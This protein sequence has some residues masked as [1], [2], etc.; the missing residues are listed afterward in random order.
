MNYKGASDIARQL[1]TSD[2]LTLNQR[3]QG[4]SPCAPT[5]ENR[6]LAKNRGCRSRRAEQLRTLCGPGGWRFVAADVGSTPM[7]YFAHGAAATGQPRARYRPVGQILGRRADFQHNILS[8][9][10]NPTQ[11]AACWFCDLACRAMASRKVD[12]KSASQASSLLNTFSDE[13]LNRR[14]KVAGRSRKPIFE[15]YAACMPRNVQSV[16]PKRIWLIERTGRG[17][18]IRRSAGRG[19]AATGSHHV[20]CGRYAKG[21]SGCRGVTDL[22]TQPSIVPPKRGRRNCAA[23]LCLGYCPNAA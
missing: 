13:M 12:N 6:G 9:V 1:E 16:G 7:A 3:V 14:V 8:S 23:W 4:S 2:K 10:K 17:A 15:P 21:T 5:I 19:T 11:A 18:A 20:H 22:D